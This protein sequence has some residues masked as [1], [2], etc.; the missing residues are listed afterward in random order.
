M[1]F[2][3]LLGVPSLIL[4]VALLWMS[5]CGSDETVDP[6]KKLTETSAEFTIQEHENNGRFFDY[7]SDTV[8]IRLL[9]FKAVDSLA[10][11]YE[12]HIGAGVYTTRSFTLNF[13][14]ATDNNIPIQLIIHKKPNL[15]CF[16]NDNGVDTV[17]H[18][19]H[20]IEPLETVVSGIYEGADTD[21][22]QDKY[23]IEVQVRPSTEPQVDLELYVQESKLNCWIKSINPTI[24]YR[25]VAT[26]TL[27]GG[28]EPCTNTL[29]LG[30]TIILSIDHKSVTIEKYFD[31]EDKTTR[32]KKIF[33][34]IRKP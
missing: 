10:D 18:I 21:A 20:F 22:P 34:G 19:L 4:A 12:W 26:G 33:K 24:G 29:L 15:T 30:H 1:W 3:N 5:G 25:G 31:S 14:N 16:P 32:I 8:V 7:S 13:Y 23:T 9:F 2:K 17:T 27:W 11:S 28:I 6:C